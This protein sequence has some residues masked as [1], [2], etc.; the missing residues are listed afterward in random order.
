VA[1]K[2]KLRDKAARFHRLFSTHDGEQVLQDLIDEFDA[3]DLFDENPHKMGWKVG[4]RDAVV[5]PRRCQR[6]RRSSQAVHRQSTDDREFN[7]D[8]RPRC[9]R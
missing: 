8:S 9:W 1:E 5:Y 2:Q 4:R 3:D 7:P 6:H